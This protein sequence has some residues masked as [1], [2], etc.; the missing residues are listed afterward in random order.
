MV[1]QKSALCGFV[2]MAER[3]RRQHVALG[4][5]RCSV[6]GCGR[7][8][9]CVYVCVCVCRWVRQSGL[10][11][12]WVSRP[13][14]PGRP[15]K[16]SS[17]LTLVCHHTMSWDENGCSTFFG[18]WGLTSCSIGATWSVFS[19]N[20]RCKGM[21]S[22]AYLLEG[23]WTLLCKRLVN[24]RFCRLGHDPLSRLSIKPILAFSYIQERL[25]N[26]QWTLQ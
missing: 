3:F 4:R 16:F 25:W 6:N 18:K 22:N 11:R 13:P 8:G 5:R 26:I 17:H 7:L 19:P 23:V 24:G 14:N 20:N 15:P 21:I 12:R 9:R 10:L 1:V 2:D